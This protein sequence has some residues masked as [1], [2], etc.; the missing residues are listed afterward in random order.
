M[1]RTHCVL[2]WIDLNERGCE[3]LSAP[4]SLSFADVNRS[5]LQHSSSSD[6]ALIDAD[7]STIEAILQ[8]RVDLGWDNS[9]SSKPPRRRTG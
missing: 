3:G 5:A 1:R 2:N 7:L 9:V 8:L 6:A 4:R